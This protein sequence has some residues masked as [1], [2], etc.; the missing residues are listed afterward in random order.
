[1]R[2][3]TLLLLV[4]LLAVCVGLAATNPTL[5]QYL[6][7]VETEMNKALERMDQSMAARDRTVIQTVFRSQGK[8]IIQGVVR[9]NT[10]RRNWG[11]LSRFE[12]RVLDEEVMVLGIAGR[13]VPLKG[14][15]EATLKVGRLAF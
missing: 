10:I 3:R 8:K 12:T 9:P 14:F 6:L 7:F 4:L 15:E 2:I 13:F 11:L 1:M 5:D